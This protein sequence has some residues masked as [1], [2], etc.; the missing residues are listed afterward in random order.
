MSGGSLVVDLVAAGL[1]P[2]D[3]ALVDPQP[4]AL[5]LGR[6]VGALLLGHAQVGAEVEQLVLDPRSQASQ[7]SGSSRVRSTPMWAFSSSTVPYAAMRALAL[8][9]RRPSPRLVSPA[10]PPRV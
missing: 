9:T 5:P 1:E 10:S 7:P 6:A 8:E 3:L 2:G 4:R